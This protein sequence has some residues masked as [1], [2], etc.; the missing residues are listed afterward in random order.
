[1]TNEDD[2]YTYPDS[3]AVLVNSRNIRDAARLDM[4]INDYASVAM[5]SLRG[6]PT[7]ERPGLE[8]LK[9]IHTRMFAPIVPGIAGRIRD[10]DVQATGTGIPYCRPDYIN[11]NLGSL[12]KKLDRRLIPL[13]VRPRR[14][15]PLPL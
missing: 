4:A 8:Y 6:E 7:P 14:R 13:T 11:E 10:V 3:G 15:P 5:A 1:L 9:E 2:K 12:F